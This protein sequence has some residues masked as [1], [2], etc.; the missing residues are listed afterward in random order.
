MIEGEI[1]GLVITIVAI[2]A[3]V[4]GFVWLLAFGR[5]PMWPDGD[6]TEVVYRAHRAIVIWDPSHH[7]SDVRERTTIA[8]ACAK[9]SWAISRAWHD[10]TGENVFGDLE[11]IGV[12]VF[13]DSAFEDRAARAIPGR[14]P[15]TVGAFLDKGAVRLGN[16]PPMPVIRASHLAHVENTG[17]PIIHELLHSLGDLYTDREHVD[18]KAWADASDSE[19]EIEERAEGLFRL[20]APHPLEASS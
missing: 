2:V 15:K 12:Q 9:A 13:E 14:D 6:R 4:T 20:V 17:Q 16:G 10:A 7:V 11:T 3:M 1:I 5:R 18:G 19:I 8:L